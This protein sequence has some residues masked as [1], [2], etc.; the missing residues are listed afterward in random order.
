MLRTR[1]VFLAGSVIVQLILY[2]VPPSQSLGRDWA[3][4]GKPRGTLRVVDL[5]IGT[6]FSVIRCYSGNLV[7]LDNE[8]NRTPDLA[9]DWRW[10]DDRTIALH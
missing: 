7:D 9:E 8:N 4:R 5:G 10:V 3:V 1:F 2:L 6:W